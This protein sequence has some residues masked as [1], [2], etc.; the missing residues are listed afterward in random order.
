MDPK[1]ARLK[2]LIKNCKHIVFFGG[3]G[4]STE[5]GIKDFR[6]KDGLYNLKSKYGRP[7]E[8]ML[9]H[10]YFYEHTD[11]FYKFY[12]E[13]MLPKGVKPN[14]AHHFLAELE[15]EKDV[16]VITQNIDGLHQEAGSKNVIEL[17]G[18][19][20]RNHCDRCGEFYSLDDLLKLKGDI[21]YCPKCHG[22]VKP[23]VVLYEEPLFDGVIEQAIY[24]IM[25]ADL[26][27]IAGTSLRVYPA[28]GLIRYYRGQHI[29]VI[30]KEHLDVL[31]DDI[32]EINEPVGEVFK[33]IDKE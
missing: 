23:D 30:N 19:I 11:T 4:V 26:F 9:S 17:H 6:S 12:K 8:E 16:T 21:P 33:K 31:G 5:S 20:L 7:Y 2:Y 22:I 18:S 29:V 14:Y 28:S 32:L 25:A 15:K 10:T 24:R 1:I 13:L 27:I 3:A